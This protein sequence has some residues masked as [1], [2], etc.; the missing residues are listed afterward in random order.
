MTF[1]EI[2][3][4]SEMMIKWVQVQNPYLE[5]TH[6]KNGL[7]EWSVLIRFKTSLVSF[8]RF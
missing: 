8:L 6:I 3:E 7:K 2:C 5:F 4:Y 1:D